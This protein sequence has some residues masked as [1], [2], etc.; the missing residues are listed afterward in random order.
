MAIFFSSQVKAGIIQFWD[1]LHSYGVSNK[2]ALEKY[3]E[4]ENALI[5]LKNRTY[6]RPCPF[7]DLGQK[8]T[9]IGTNLFPF[10]YIYVYTDKKSKS[11]WSFSYT[12]DTTSGDLFIVT[13]K[14]SKLIKEEQNIDI[15]KVKESELKKIIFESVRKIIYNKNRHQNERYYI[16]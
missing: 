16:N 12:I 6:H 11:K 9:R 1:S 15:I 10:L 2:R 5:S 7:K 8:K 13:M 3:Y 14:N 4:M